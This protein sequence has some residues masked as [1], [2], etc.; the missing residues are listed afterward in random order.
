MPHLCGI[1][2]PHDL[3]SSLVC[4]MN[5]LSMYNQIDCNNCGNWRQDRAVY[6][7]I[8]GELAR[9]RVDPCRLSTIAGGRSCLGLHTGHSLLETG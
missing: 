2:A 4:G 5:H 6:D 1:L 9:A 8:N 7:R 3:S